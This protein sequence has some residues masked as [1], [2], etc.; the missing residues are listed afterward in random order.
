MI[1]SKQQVCE[2]LLNLNK[3]ELYDIVNA[4]L[5]SIENLMP[6]NISKEDALENDKKETFLVC[7]LIRLSGFTK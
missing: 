7:W 6:A 3:S 2:F 4:A 1:N 5:A